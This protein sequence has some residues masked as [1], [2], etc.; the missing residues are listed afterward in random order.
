MSPLKEK[1]DNNAYENKLQNINDFFYIVLSE[2]TE[3]IPKYNTYP[4]IKTYS[5]TFSRSMD[6]LKEV[7]KDLFLLKNNVEKDILTMNRNTEQINNQIHTLEKKNIILQ[8]KIRSLM[9]TDGAGEG[10]LDDIKLLHNQQ[11]IGNWLLFTINIGSIIVLY[12]SY[13]L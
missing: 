11:Y 1:K 5:D 8:K 10:M 4:N 13:A 7:E 12:K 6:N 2:V 9:N 3:I